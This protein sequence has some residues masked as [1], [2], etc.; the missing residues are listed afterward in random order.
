MMDLPVIVEVWSVDSLAECLDA[1]E[2]E[3]YRKLWS[4]VPAEGESPKG[5]DI[6]HLLTEEEKRE[7]VVAIKEEFPDEEC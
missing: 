7:L 5:K 2:P 6:W 3:L 4:F 1:V